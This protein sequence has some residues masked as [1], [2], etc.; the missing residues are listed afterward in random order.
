VVEARLRLSES[1][2]GLGKPGGGC[3]HRLASIA[4]TAMVLSQAGG[5][6]NGSAFASVC[7]RGRGHDLI[8]S[9]ASNKE[10]TD[11]EDRGDKESSFHLSEIVADGP[12]GWGWRHSSLT[13]F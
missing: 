5:S 10:K 7:R 9:R 2:A 3:A 8:L 1:V 11:A 4:Y 6:A 13:E 12:V